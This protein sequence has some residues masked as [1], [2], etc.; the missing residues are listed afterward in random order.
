V[1]PPFSGPSSFFL[2]Y[3]A[4][5]FLRLLRFLRFLKDFS[6]FFGFEKVKGRVGVRVRVRVEIL[7]LLLLSEGRLD[8]LLPERSDVGQG[9]GL[10]RF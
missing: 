10:S 5:F 3:F 7:G 8:G 9:L 2:K 1:F 4:S 6:G